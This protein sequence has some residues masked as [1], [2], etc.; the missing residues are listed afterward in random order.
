[1]SVNEIL[2]YLDSV[3]RY[4]TGDAEERQAIGRKLRTLRKRKGLNTQKELAELANVGVETISRV[5]NGANVEVDTLAKIWGAFAVDINIRE[6][7]A[8]QVAGA[9]TTAGQELTPEQR[10]AQEVAAL[11]MKIADLDVRA[12]LRAMLEGYV[13]LQL[14]STGASPRPDA[15]TAPVDP[16]TSRKQRVR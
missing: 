6:K 15:G 10:E 16:A 3:E 7:L 5:E 12:K 2:D 13:T 4:V 1:M 14:A 9:E 8:E 11:W